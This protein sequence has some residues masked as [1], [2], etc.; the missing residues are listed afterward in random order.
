MSCR[1][2]YHTRV[3]INLVAQNDSCKQVNKSHPTSVCVCNRGGAK[4]DSSDEKEK[5]KRGDD[6][7][8]AEKRIFEAEKH[9]VEVVEKA[10]EDEV[11]TI[12]H[13]MPHHEKKEEESKKKEKPVKVAKR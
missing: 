4:K 7:E 8:A 10:I 5:E 12:F 6:Y 1:G 13:G 3:R 2:T 11:D 9:A